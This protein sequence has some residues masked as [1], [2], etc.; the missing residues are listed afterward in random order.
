VI[1]DVRERRAGD[2]RVHAAVEK[3]A[4]LPEFDETAR[5]TF[6]QRLAFSYIRLGEGAKAEQ[7]FRELIDAF[8][9]VAGADSPHV[10]RVRMN[11]AQAFMIQSKHEDVVKETTAIYPDFVSRLGPDHELTLQLLSTRAQSEASLGR[12]DDAVRDDLTAHDL[13]IHKQGP[14]SFFAIAP[15]IDG[16]LAQCRSGHTREGESNARQAYNDSAKAFGLR[17]GLT[18]GAAYTLASCLIPANKLDEATTLLQQIDLSALAQLTGN[19]DCGADIKLTQ[20]EIAHRRGDDA[21]AGADL[22]SIAP[23]FTKKDAE[24]YQKQAFESLKAALD[25]S[26]H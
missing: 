25:K 20:A 16:S 10:L 4:A 18:G 23:I 1:R 6:K 17:A 14:L 5:L 9:R 11:L 19:P 2:I 8:T 12:F 24:P 7:L 13:A 21:T 26:S 15:L 3:S 22:Q